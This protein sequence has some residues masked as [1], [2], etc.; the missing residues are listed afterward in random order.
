MPLS[1][2]IGVVKGLL[3]SE[4][5][6]RERMKKEEP[7]HIHVACAIIERDGLILSAQRKAGMR[8]ALKWEFPGGKI[9]PGENPEQ[10]LR[11]E[12]MEELGISVDIVRQLDR[13]THPYSFFTVT[14]YPFVC[15]IASGEPAMIEHAAFLWLPPDELLSLD[16]AEADIPLIKH[17]LQLRRG[18][19]LSRTGP[20]EIPDAAGRA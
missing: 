13:V 1:L 18:T 8:L 20:A 6:Q 12:L 5:Y 4:R 17:F 9:D 2:D 15:T 19:D 11:R 7:G 16:W 3:F 14:L 10:C